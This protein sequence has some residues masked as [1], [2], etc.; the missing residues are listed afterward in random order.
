MRRSN[1]AMATHA[2]T[3]AKAVASRRQRQRADCATPPRPAGDQPAADR[4]YSVRAGWDVEQGP[5][6]GE[7][8]PWGLSACARAAADVRGVPLW[9]SL[10]PDCK[11]CV[12]LPMVNS[13]AAAGTRGATSISKTFCSSP[14]RSARSP[15]RWRCAVTSTAPWRDADRD[16]FEGVLVGDEGGFGPRLQ[17]NEQ[18]IS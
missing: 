14:W 16:G 15:K 10:A 2:L 8:H 7:C 18:A 17:S 1:C 4:P 13:S 12:P 11:P 6:G 9:R 5:V 3:T